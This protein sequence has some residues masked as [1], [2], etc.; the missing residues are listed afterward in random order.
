MTPEEL[1]NPPRLLAAPDVPG[2]ASM[3]VMSVMNV[4]GVR[5]QGTSKGADLPSDVTEA[6]YEYEV[7][8]DATEKKAIEEGWG[9]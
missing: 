4:D 5:D 7:L 9:A 8:A 2:D 6:Y 3:N 1:S